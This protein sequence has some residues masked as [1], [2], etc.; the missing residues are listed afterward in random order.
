MDKKLQEWCGL[1]VLSGH[2]FVNTN[3][4]I[5]V[6]DETPPEVSVDGEVWIIE[7]NVI[8]KKRYKTPEAFKSKRAD[9]MLVTAIRGE[10]LIPIT[11]AAEAED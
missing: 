1:D 9:Q 8:S 2:F 7:F 4:M 11:G 3:M 5:G 10:D 6:L